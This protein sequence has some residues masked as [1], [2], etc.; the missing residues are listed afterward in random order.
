MRARDLAGCL[1]VLAFAGSGCDEYGPRIYTARSYRAGA[2][3][4]ELSTAIGVVR[5]GELHASCPEACLSLD[6]ALYVSTVCPPLPARALPVKPEV[7]GCALALAAFRAESTC[8]VRDAGLDG[9]LDAG[10]LDAG[11][12]ENAAGP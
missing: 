3:C 2:G 9:G 11:A 7:P 4:L 10:M 5:A 12:L 6:D 8:G 1:A